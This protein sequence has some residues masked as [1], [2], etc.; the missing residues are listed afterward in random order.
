MALLVEMSLFVSKARSTQFAQMV[1]ED[2]VPPLAH[3]VNQ[4][5]LDQEHRKGGVSIAMQHQ[6]LA[7]SPHPPPHRCLFP[8]LSRRELGGLY[9]E[10]KTAP[11]SQ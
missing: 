4:V 3:G 7:S 6:P 5:V 8:R 10:T 1:D 11:V 9:G 2:V